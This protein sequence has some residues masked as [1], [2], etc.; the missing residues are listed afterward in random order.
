MQH[1]IDYSVQ[2]LQPSR[3]EN[4]RAILGVPAEVYVNLR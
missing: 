1:K 3:Y 4:E 2:G